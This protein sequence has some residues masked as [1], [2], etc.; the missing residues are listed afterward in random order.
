M[1]RVH[2][3]VP[4]RTA[5]QCSG[6]SKKF[7]YEVVKSALKAYDDKVSADESG[8]RP[9]YRPGEWKTKE[10]AIE[11]QRKKNDWYKTRGNDAVIFTPA[12]PRS[13]L[14]RR[15]MEEIKASG[16]KIKVIEQTGIS[17]KRLL[18]RSNPSKSKI[19]GKADCMVLLNGGKGPCDV[20]GITYSGTLSISSEEGGDLFSLET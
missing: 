8:I 11:K 7:R 2:A 20:H 17:L 15:Y 13:E 5:S 6:Y 19:Y 18:Q 14:Q 16:L 10:R 9:L 4:K 12:T 3:P 1:R